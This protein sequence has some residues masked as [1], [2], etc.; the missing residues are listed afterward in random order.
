MPH[1]PLFMYIRLTAI[2]LLSLA[3]ALF[4][5]NDAG[6]NPDVSPLSDTPDFL[7]F[8]NN[9]SFSQEMAADTIITRESFFA[10]IS[11]FHNCLKVIRDDAQLDVTTDTKLLPGDVVET[12]ARH[13]AILDFHP[14]GIL[15]LYPSSKIGFDPEG[16]HITLKGAELHFENHAHT[17]S[18]PEILHC[19]DESI[20]HSEEPPPVSFGVHCRGESGM[21]LASKQGSVWWSCQGKPCEIK[22]GNGV[23]GRFT[24]ANYSSITLPEKPIILDSIVAQTDTIIDTAAKKKHHVAF[25]WSSIP[26]ADHYLVHIYQKLP[27][28]VQK[29]HHMVT[30]HHKNEFSTL[31]PESGEYTIRVM[32]I[33]FYGVSGNWS[34]PF[35]FVIGNPDTGT[36]MERYPVE[37]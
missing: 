22:Q 37:S 9:D 33:D 17:S 27:N 13:F 26:M 1:K 8:V 3:V 20:Y 30:L 31:L 12:C 35:T 34:T 32:A 19:F 15:I 6:E 2:L 24:T 21:I 11:Y 10:N 5:L 16:T 7:K 36:A 4:H 28:Q 18:I 14:D 23:M 25:Q 29:K